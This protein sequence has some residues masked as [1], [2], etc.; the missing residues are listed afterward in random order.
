METTLKLRVATDV[1]ERWRAAALQHGLTLSALIR[2]AVEAYLLSSGVRESAEAVAPPSAAIHIGAKVSDV[3]ARGNTVSP[4][5][6]TR[7][8]N[9][10]DSAPTKN[11]GRQCWCNARIS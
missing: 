5:R 9:H 8:C 2:E 11:Q 7:G 3:V 10:P 1:S 6:R 4:P